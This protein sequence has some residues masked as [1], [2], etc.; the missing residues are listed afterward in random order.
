MRM[1]NTDDKMRKINA[2][3]KVRMEKCEWQCAD[4]KIPMM[5]IFFGD[6]ILELKEV[7]RFI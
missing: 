1:E 2:S 6:N 4:N 7:F 5:M 3:V